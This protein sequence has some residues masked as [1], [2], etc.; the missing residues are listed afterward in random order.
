MQDFVVSIFFCKTKTIY[1]TVPQ[2]LLRDQSSSQ[3]VI[4]QKK[5]FTKSCYILYI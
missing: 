1:E 5:L 4:L 3:T 2:D